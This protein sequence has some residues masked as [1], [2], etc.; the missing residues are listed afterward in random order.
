MKYVLMVGLF[1]SL[2]Q[3]GELTTFSLATEYDTSIKKATIQKVEPD[4]WTLELQECQLVKNDID[5]EIGA[6]S[7]AT[8]CTFERGYAS[9]VQVESIVGLL[10]RFKLFNVDFQKDCPL[11]LACLGEEI[12]HF[13]K[14]HVFYLEND[15]T[16]WTLSM[17]I[18]GQTCNF[19]ARQATDFERKMYIKIA[20]FKQAVLNKTMHG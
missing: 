13:L 5:S 12:L 8:N 19:Y 4:V 6:G 20:A 9:Q 1:V 14:S 15:N 3:A 17:E 16:V 7:Q 18:N 10:Q 11:L 2:I